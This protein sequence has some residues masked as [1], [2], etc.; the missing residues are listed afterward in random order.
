M[1]ISIITV[2]YNRAKTI[3][4][5]VESVLSQNYTDIEYIVVDGAST[6]G[7]REI[8]EKYRDRISV[9]VS[10]PDSGLY[11]ALNKGIR[12][13]TGDAVGVLHSDDVF[14]SCDAVSAI[15]DAFLRH[16]PD[17]VYGDGIYVNPR[18]R[19]IVRNWVSGDFSPDKIR[20]GWLPL[21]TTVY[22]R[23]SLAE[24]YG[25]YDES[26]R[27]AADSE[28]LLRYML[29]PD[30]NIYRLN[31]YIVS[32]GTGGVSTRLSKSIIKWREDFRSYKRHSI[33]PYIALPQ[34]ILSKLKQ[35]IF[36]F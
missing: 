28:F 25:L 1:K 29:N 35:F 16:N 3:A 27:I 20:N 6:D 17:M 23:R 24:R 30:I 33:N 21:H 18:S 12:L 2:C 36:K 31:R 32:M 11:N 5:T 34:K 13:A 4:N 26:Y 19:R 9:Y 8:I 7:T 14:Y 10:E 15:A 22:I